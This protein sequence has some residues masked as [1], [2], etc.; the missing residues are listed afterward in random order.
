MTTNTAVLLVDPLNDFLHP[1]GKLYAS[2]EASLQD[3]Q[4][5]HHMKE[6]ILAARKAEI[7]IFYG[8]HQPFRDGAFFGWKHMT[9]SNQRVEKLHL[10]EEK[11]GGK[12]LEGLEPDPA[13]GDVIVSR[14]WNSSA[15]QNTDLSLQ[16][17]QREITH[18]VIAGLTTNTCVESTARYARE[19]GYHVTLISD[20]SVA[21]SLKLQEA[22]REVWPL[23]G[24][25]K[26]TGEW[27]ASLGVRGCNVLNATETKEDA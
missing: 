12:I 11:W 24:D 3:T 13:N 21:F 5:I 23:L 8:L 4:G 1:D 27:V 2:I 7:P 16:L 17:R 19:L 18:L 14:H 15:F 26:T 20:A 22:A 10:F 6:V 25:V 9:P